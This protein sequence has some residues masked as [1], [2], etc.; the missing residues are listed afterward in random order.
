MSDPR[1][2]DFIEDFDE[3]AT[4][5]LQH[6][7][8]GS[9]VDH[10]LPIPIEDIAT[11]KMMLDIED[12]VYLSPDDSVQGIITF[13][14]GI[15][16]VYDWESKEYVGYNAN[17]GTIL[18]DADIKNQGRFNNIL[19]HE[20]FH[21]YKHRL[22]FMYHSKNDEN[23]EFA[24]RCNQKIDI[25][26]TKDGWSDIDKMEYQA[27]MIAPK[28]L[29]PKVAATLKIKEL[30]QKNQQLY[31]TS[32]RTI[33]CEQVIVQ[34]AEFFRV[35]KQSAAIRMCEL[36]Y[37]E[38]KPYCTNDALPILHTHVP[39]KTGV[40]RQR[41]QKISLNEAFEVFCN[42]EF[43]FMMLVTNSYRYADGYFVLNDR[44]YYDNGMNSLTQYARDH[45]AE[46]TIDFSYRYV[47]KNQDI[48]INL[49]MFRRDI[50][51]KKIPTFDN[52]AQ[53]TDNYNH[54]KALENIKRTFEEQYQLQS[55]IHEGTNQKI[56]KIMQLKKWNTSIFQDKTW[57]SPMDYSRIQKPNHIF[58]LPAYTAMA[59]G[60]GLSLHD[61]EEI[62]RAS[63]LAY[64]TGD[65]EHCAYVFVLSTFQGCSIEE[66]N[67]VLMSLGVKPLGTKSKK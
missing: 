51:Y 54:A 29:M 3:E 12:T 45:L 34:I 21:W 13:S 25:N 26:G 61:T 20:C 39:A 63:G 4:K 60:L 8:Y 59:I 16:D 9:L 46:C 32:D 43:F 30:F 44:K 5:F 42:S 49:H 58:Q 24:F 35:S 18:I 14:D 38:A 65:I 41:Q 22:Y 23:G 57:L 56:W 55:A 31:S 36:G 33:L 66:C 40:G 15:I 7:G 2:P 6:Y 11:K 10:P 53:N 62:L 64:N 67:E 28:I 27:K 48:P 52:S 17:R 19:A 50:E 1:K 37:K 47:R